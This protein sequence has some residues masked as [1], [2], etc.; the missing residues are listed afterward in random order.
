MENAVGYSFWH[1]TLCVDTF[2]DG[3]TLRSVRI[4]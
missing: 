1:G 3:G 2:A 4:E